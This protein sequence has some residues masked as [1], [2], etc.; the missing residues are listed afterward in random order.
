MLVQQIL[1]ILFSASVLGTFDD[2]RLRVHGQ[3]DME[4][5]LFEKI[6]VQGPRSKD[7]ADLRE[8]ICVFDFAVGVDVDDSD[9]VLYCYSCRALGVGLKAGLG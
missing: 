5:V 1:C 7:L 4:L 3:T 6:D 8:E 9:L 2:G